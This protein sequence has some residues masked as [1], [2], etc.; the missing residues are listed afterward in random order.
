[1]PGV[2]PT[3]IPSSEAPKPFKDG[4]SMVQFTTFHGS[5]DQRKALQFLQQFDTVFQ[6]GNYTESS[7]LTRVAGFLKD[8]ALQWWASQQNQPFSP[9]TWADFKRFFCH[10]WLTP[11][12]EAELL[13]QWNTLEMK[14]GENL[15][16]YNQ[17]YWDAFLP[18]SFFKPIPLSD[19]L[20][21]YCCGLPPA[22][23]KYS[24]KHKA[25]SIQDMMDHVQSGYDLVHVQ[26]GYDLVH[27]PL[28]QKPKPNGQGYR[29]TKFRNNNN[30]YKNDLS[31]SSKYTTLTP[32]QKLEYIKAG[33][34]FKCSE[35]GHRSYEC[36]KHP[37][38]YKRKS[39]EGGPKEDIHK[40]PTPTLGLVPDMIGSSSLDE[41]SELCRAWG[42]VRDQEALIFFD[43]GA[44]ANF[45]S[46]DLAQ[47]LGI[48][49]YE[50]GAQ[51]EAN[52]AAPGVSVPAT[53]LIGKLRLHIQGYVGQE[54]FHIMELDG[55]DVLL[56]MPWFHHVDATLN[57]KGRTITLKHKGK[58]LVLDVKLKGESIPC[59]ICL[60]RFKVNKEESFCVLG[61]CAR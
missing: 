4:G 44:R 36:P 38:S 56:G 45:I 46:P 1:M 26:S 9:R 16:A 39:T 25:T 49:D 51:L 54:D 31:T 59:C 3:A 53:P 58:D 52:L 50:L 27:E 6:S 61:L 10:V 57:A 7:K 34:C 14:T 18:V 55:C 24:L 42:K 8:N 37:K 5:K 23:L 12:Y 2:H 33:Q 40:K 28:H 17:R 47:C 30:R 13:A 60:F 21:K 22:L 15:E 41:D 19:Q 48:K 43:T 35:Q 11:A 29:F 32:Q 20:E